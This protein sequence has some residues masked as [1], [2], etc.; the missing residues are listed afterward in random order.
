MAENET[1]V[2]YKAIADFSAVA[3]E[4]RKAKA[5]IAALKAEEAGLN[6]A[7]VSGA[8]AST[9]ATQGHTKAIS[10]DT[11]AVHESANAH[12]DHNTVL[13]EGGA[14]ASALGNATSKADTVL[15][16]ATSTISK[17]AGEARRMATE[18]ERVG[19]A[20][21]PAASK[22]TNFQRGVQR[23]VPWVEKI[24][25]GF[26]KLGKWR[27]KLTP[28][29]IALVPII[30]GL[31]SLMNPLVAGIGALGGAGIG[32]ASSLGQVAGAALAAI[33]ALFSLLSI[34]G[35]LKV[36]F[37]GIGGVFSAFKAAKKA[38]ASGGGGGGGGGSSQA[39]ISQAEK[40]A[41]A[42]ENLRRAT[43]NL[44]WAEEDLAD[45]RKDYLQRLKDL[46]QT[47]KDAAAS[48]KRLTAQRENAEKNLARILAD[49]NSTK[50]EKMAAQAA[51]EDAKTAEQKAKDNN[52]KLQDDLKD[53]KKKGMKGDR[54]VIMA[55][56][57]LTDAIWAQRDAQIAL[58]NAKKGDAKASGGGASAN[59][60]LAAALAKLSP[61]A[62]K[63]VEAI[64]AMDKAW[65]KVK[66]T[67]QES[68]F[69]KIVNDTGK[70]RSMLPTIQSLLSDTAGAL[71]DVAHEF[72]G[73]ISSP[74]WKSDLILLGKQN[75]PLIHAIGGGLNVLWGVFK[76]LTVIAMPFLIELAKGFKKGA[77]NIAAMV[78]E[79]RKSGSLSKWLMGDKETGSKGVLGTLR[80][81]WQIIKNIAKT[82]F[83]FAKAAEAF[84]GWITDGI[85]KTTEGW[86]ASSEAATKKGSPFKKW[87]ED[88][89]PLLSEISRMFG[90]F[91][92]WFGKQA[93]DPKN[94]KQMTEIFKKITDDLGPKLASLF[95]ALSKANIG[96]KF[97]DSL[98]KIVD[99]ITTLVDGPGTAV[100]FDTLNGL[101]DILLTVIKMPVIGP[102]LQ[103]LIGAAAAIGAMSF[104]A[105]FTGLE[106]LIG[107]LIKL[108][109]TGGILKFFESLK[110]VL[111]K[112]FGITGKRYTG[113]SFI[114]A[115]FY[116]IAD[117]AKFLFGKLGKLFGLFKGL[118]KLL[119]GLKG[120]KWLGSLLD[121]F[122]VLLSGGGLKGFSTL[123][124]GFG[125][126]KGFASIL[127]GAGGPL[128]AIASILGTIVG[129]VISNNAPEGKDGSGQ[130]LGGN[131]LSGAATGAGIGGSVGLLFGGIG[132]VPGAIIG[133]L[134]GA[135][136]GFFGSAKEDIDQ[137]FTDFVKGWNE[138][139]GTTLPKWWNDLTGGISK[140]FGDFGKLWDEYWGVQVPKFW[141]DLTGGISK[142][143]GDFGKLWDEYWGVQVPKFWNDLG[144]GA[145]KWFDDLGTSW[146]DFWTKTFPYWA[147]YAL[148]A[149]VKW[150][151]GIGPA[152]TTFWTE[153]FPKW[154]TSA[155]LAVGQWFAGIGAAWTTFWT[156][157]FPLWVTQASAAVTQWFAGIGVAWT[158]FWTVTFPAWISSASA[159]VRSW[160]SSIG[161]A[162]N[163]FWAVTF[164]KWLA[165]AKAQIQ[166]WVSGIGPMWDKFWNVTLPGFGRD[167]AK[168]ATDFV[169]SVSTAWGRW[170]DGVKN[171]IGKW[172][173]DFWGNAGAGFGAGHGDGT[174]TPHNGGE[175][176]RA[177]GGGVPGHGN[178]DTVAARLTPGEFVVRKG[179]V[180]RVG[181]DNLVKLNSG[182]MSYAQLLA[183]A[184]SSSRKPKDGGS[185]LV[186][187]G[188]GLV[189]TM[190]PTNSPGGG[191]GP[192]FGGGGNTTVNSVTFGDV[193]IQNPVPER[194]TNSLTTKTQ[195]LAHL[196][197]NAGDFK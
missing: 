16:S 154:V 12:R 179:I 25:N 102:V 142:W 112:L 158:T 129:D 56:R 171:T 184:A 23:A 26:D 9:A 123:I 138:F 73:M 42:R 147:G 29:F 67:V 109:K 149:T 24:N 72:I 193:I 155:T 51:V 145:T 54:A 100:F 37:S 50:A 191:R 98:I 133:G 55:Q 27:P 59:N 162:W 104:V 124:K 187:N 40:V 78:K 34:V 143:F 135:L 185:Q 175:I 153:T 86:L 63:F 66:R 5:E 114:K 82:L 1:R 33:P 116:G 156:V 93:A 183:A 168:I 57:A 115:M 74:E 76:D 101:L 148:G 111:M 163:N 46:E 137:F 178:S 44:K 17:H 77:E 19:A 38:G 126:L 43:E 117:G 119:S 68:F 71:G 189:P 172:W 35:A 10:N 152:W 177:G 125:S 186:F 180:D 14:A 136:V 8:K 84:G 60:A 108:Y 150:F 32:L 45:A 190:A 195:Q 173:T 36:A 70:L 31:L 2:I 85:Q 121:G 176:H 141:N 140:W 94:I 99:L 88:I 21:T 164:P 64:L 107:W 139:W 61:S 122:K 132:A 58:I 144:A 194:A 53:M 131:T 3:R 90:T 11:N 160:I 182:V 146:T 174:Q 159:A 113:L 134:I 92:K 96:P 69:S 22:M 7:S 30:A 79:A 166:K 81:W 170:W 62:R 106:N 103:M 4:A 188:G 83:N 13:K 118:P 95:D 157:T 52:A 47:A 20:L 130:R 196:G 28:P 80:Q 18:T 91:F 89:K 161:P 65:T 105:K 48:E 167:L 75:V 97:V 41:R 169:D 49:P 127:K 181:I 39:E 128:A 15:K 165:N 192:S 6:A 151:E 120:F 87:L 197:L 110:T